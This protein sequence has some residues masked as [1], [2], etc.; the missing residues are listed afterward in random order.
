MFPELARM[1]VL[2]IVNEWLPAVVASM[3]ISPPE[4]AWNV[5]LTAVEVL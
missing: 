5:V 3:K 1:S 2:L 4:G